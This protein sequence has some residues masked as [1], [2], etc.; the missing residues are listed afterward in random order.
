[1]GSIFQMLSHGFD[2]RGAVPLCWAWFTIGF[3]RGRSGAYGGLG[4]PNMPKYATDVYD[5]FMLGSMSVL[6]G[7]S[8]GFVGEISNAS[9]AAFQVNNIMGGDGRGNR[10]GIWSAAYMLLWLY[11]RVIIGPQ[12]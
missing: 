8:S 2:L 12:V 1:M 7:T 9:E 5:L 10:R 3:I 6:P 4:E 11:R